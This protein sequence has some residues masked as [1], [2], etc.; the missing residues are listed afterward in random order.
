MRHRAELRSR[1]ANSAGLQGL[2]GHAQLALCRY[3]CAG[4]WSWNQRVARTRCLDDYL[5]HASALAVT[6]WHDE[7]CGLMPSHERLAAS[8][9]RFA[10]PAAWISIIVGVA[11]LLG[12]ILD[13]QVLKSVAPGLVSMKANTALAFVFSGTALADAG[14]RILEQRLTDLAERDPL[15]NL[16]NRRRFEEALEHELIRSARHSTRPR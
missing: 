2:D 7:R 11:V 6:H 14:R 8:I 1:F 12:W 3:T 13:V 10:G 16:Y 15:T 5:T 4:G 9:H